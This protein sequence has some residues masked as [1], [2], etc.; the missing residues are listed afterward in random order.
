[1]AP[2]KKA[3]WGDRSDSDEPPSPLA[4]A[5]KKTAPDLPPIDEPAATNPSKPAAKGGGGGGAAD[6]TAAVQ[7][8]SAAEAHRVI[9]K[10]AASSGAVRALVLDAVKAE[11][12]QSKGPGA[13][14]GA[15]SGAPPAAKGG[16]VPATPAAAGPGKDKAWGKL[17]ASE[18]TAAV[19]LGHSEASWENQDSPEASAMYWKKLNDKMRK[20]CQALG[21]TQEEWDADAPDEPDPKAAPAK[22][23]PKEN[24]TATAAP[25][26]KPKPPTAAEVAAQKAKVVAEEAAAVAEAAEAAEAKAAAGPVDDDDGWATVTTKRKKGGGGGGGGGGLPAGLPAALAQN[27]AML[28]GL[29]QNP[30][31]LRQLMQSPEVQEMLQSPEA[32]AQLGINP[33]MLQAMMGGLAGGGGGMMQIEVTPEDGEAIS[34]LMALGFPRGAAIQAFMACDKDE[35]LAAN[36][37]FDQGN[38]L[39]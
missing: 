7:K 32:M 22:A 27:P 34:R 6:V 25:P 10:L 39:E 2:K 9:C 21:Y 12:A 18:R 24:G 28:E 31:L 4:V 11:A 5:S 38:D 13:K 8:L 15:P 35:N 29:L 14:A 16:A 37:L 17:T 33:E 19:T 30:E 3:A 20:A 36:F 23:V 26:P 1:M